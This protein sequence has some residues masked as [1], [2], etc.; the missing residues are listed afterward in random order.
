MKK[1][2]LLHEGKAKKVYTLQETEEK[3]HLLVQYKDTI[4]A[5]N[6]R[7]I[8]EL[9]EKG[10]LNNKIS[11][12]IFSFLEKNNIPTHYLKRVSDNEMLVKRVQ[13][14]PLEVVVRNIVS[15]TL[16]DRIGFT[17]GS[18]LNEPVVEFYYKHDELDDP[19]L[20]DFHIKTLD[21]ATK[22]EV[23]YLTRQA[24]KINDML[25]DYFLTRD[26]LLVDYKLEFGFDIEDKI[27]LADEI[28]PDSCRLWDRETHKKLDKDRFRQGLGDVIEG[29]KEV[30]KRISGGDS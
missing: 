17:E 9:P 14:I 18:E 15:G 30:W 7:I 5:F 26:L 24:L 12:E 22:E 23:D 20:N 2:Y 16:R 28:T 4:T 8:D 25:V 19:L 6:G 11:S 29:Y 27:I 3:D 1:D 13:V 10:V 21:L